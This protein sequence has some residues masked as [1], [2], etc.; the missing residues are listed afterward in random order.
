LSESATRRAA[1]AETKAPSSFETIIVESFEATAIAPQ[2]WDDF[3][4]GV[5]GDMYMSFD[6]C[7]IWWRHYGQARTLRIF[8]FRNNGRLVGLAPMFV[9]RVRLGPVSLKLG[10][11]VGADHALTIF[12]LPIAEDFVEAAYAHVLSN[13]I[14]SDRCDAVWIGFCPGDD[15]TLP[16]LRAAV[17]SLASLASMV[18][19]DSDA[20]HTIFD[21]PTTFDGYLK[22]LDSRQRQNYRR[23]RK[24][25][26]NAF[27]VEREII[28]DPA[29]AAK[30]FADFELA[31]ERQ[32]K[33]EGK[34]GHFGDWPGA[35]EFNSELVDRLS[36]S[37]RFRMVQ[38]KANGAII[39]EQYAFV[40]GDRCYWR[41]PARTIDVEFEKFGLGVLGLVQLIEC[42]IAEGVRWIEAG[43]GH[44]EYKIHFGGIESKTQTCVIAATNRPFVGVRFRLFALLS[45]LLNFVY[46]KLWFIRVAAQF[47]SLRRPLWRT[48]IR[49]RL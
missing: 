8:I 21:L 17:H 47:P 33:A 24:L 19:D 15:P 40:F 14:G 22:S 44:Y 42:V 36:K 32:W 46:Y 1:Q 27:T 10:K 20:P 39:S 41:L 11:R 23:R 12:S 2:E 34:L 9:E 18:R 25:L 30:S 38:L 49:S 16:G 29:L 7:R 13:L 31:H 28:S 3:V 4:L 43:V 5:R 48:W 35:S 37:G 6:W 45:S 26:Q